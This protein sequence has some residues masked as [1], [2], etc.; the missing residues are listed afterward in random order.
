V[1]VEWPNGAGSLGIDGKNYI[2]QQC[3]WHSPS[4]HTL[5]GDRLHVPFLK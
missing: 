1:Q 3:H 4:E 5:N 2:L